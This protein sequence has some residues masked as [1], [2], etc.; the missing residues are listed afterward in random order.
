MVIINVLLILAG[1]CVGFHLVT[2]RFL[3]P[4]RLIFV[5]GRKGAGKS[6]VLTKIAYRYLRQGREVYSTEELSFKIKGEIKS[7]LKIEPKKIYLYQFQPG[8]VILIDEVSLIWDNRNFKSMDPK[9][10][11][12]FRYQRHYKVRT[13]LFSQTFDIDKK[14]RDLSDDMY[15]VNKFFRVWAVARHM[16]RKPVVV[17]PS[18]E[19]P[20]RI[21]DDI[22]EDGLLLAPFGGCI[23][24]FIPHWAKLFD[25][26]KKPEEPTSTFSSDKEVIN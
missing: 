25:S 12:W 10:V 16:V 14:L 1:V 8:S 22:I 24:A 2:R 5:F 26:F 9:V 3:N 7:T 6:T 18:A 21:D 11:E 4:H 23:I 20:A 19:S 13:Y 17:H 15:L